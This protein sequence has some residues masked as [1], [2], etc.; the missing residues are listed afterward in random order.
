[1]DDIWRIDFQLGWDIDRERELEEENIRARIDAMLGRGAA[2][3]L[4][5]CSIY[6]FQCRRM[7][8]FRHGRV[9]FA[10]D[11]AHQV[12]PFGARGANSGAQDADNLGWKLDLILRD[13]APESLIDSYDAERRYAADENILN[14]TR[15][16]DFLTP[17]SEIGR[18]FRNATLQL[19]RDR[20][21]ARTLV[22]SG[23][24]SVPCVYDRSP[25]NGEDMLRGPSVSRPGA[26]CPDAPHG[27]G[28]LLDHLGQ[29]FML[30][31][32]NC[33][34]PDRVS[35]GGVA[36]ARL[37]ID[38]PAG[39]LAQRYL[40]SARSGLYLIRPDQHVAA[41]WADFDERAVRRALR[42]AIGRE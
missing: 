35:A 10:G 37:S 40:G 30:L 24:L 34:C 5:W 6:T 29:A 19:A 11:S 9:L 32:L 39:R 25:L 14:S 18:I 15:S 22:N 8:K 16:T 36:A 27:D 20:A 13:L 28:F 31:A 21:F 33:E 12:S 38:A 7:K 42:R 26:P 1:P 17:K 3:E 41:R 4:D 2:Y 23:R